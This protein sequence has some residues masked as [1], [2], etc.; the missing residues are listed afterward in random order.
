VHLKASLLTMLTCGLYSWLG[1][2]QRALAEYMDSNI[3]LDA[4]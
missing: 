3:V 2:Q 4:K 1:Y